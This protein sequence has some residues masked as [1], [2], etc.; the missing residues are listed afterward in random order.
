MAGWNRSS[1]ASQPTPKKKPSALRGAVAGLIVVA[2]GAACFVMFSGGDAKPAAK[3]EKKPAAIK[4]VKPAAAP[5]AAE[6]PVK[7]AEE[8]A[9]QT[10]APDTN[11]VWISKMRYVKKMSNG[12]SVMVFVDDPD[13]PKPVPIFENGLNNF[14]TNF[15]T[16]GDDI[17]ETPMEVSND[18]VMQALMEKIEIKEDDS[19]TVKFQKEAVMVLREELRKYIKEGNTVADFIRDI[20]RRQRMEAEHVREARGMI[21]ESLSKDDPAQA[22]ELY[23]AINKHMN[24]KGLPKVRLARKFLKMMEVAE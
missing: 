2:L 8:K 4:E 10:K 21:M 22:R 18:D 1:G 15:T 16:P 23:N 17:P 13:A 6:E 5:K 20:Q 14:L 12:A 19:D 9:V 7:K 24:E 11:I 3:A